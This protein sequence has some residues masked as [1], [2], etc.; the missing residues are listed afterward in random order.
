MEK[1]GQ[2]G[3]EVV[4]IQTEPW[5]G[6]QVR[7]EWRRIQDGLMLPLPKPAPSVSTGPVAQCEGW[8]PAG[9]LKGESPNPGRER[10]RQV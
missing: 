3:A 1:T 2:A 6:A 8:V 9:I 4:R 5:G 7:D 10:R